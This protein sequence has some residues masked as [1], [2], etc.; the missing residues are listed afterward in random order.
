MLEYDYI[1]S[2]I[3]GDLMPH[4]ITENLFFS[5]HNNEFIIG[6]MPYGYRIYSS[7]YYKEYIDEIPSNENDL[8]NVLFENKVYKHP[9]G[10]I[11]Y[12]PTKKAYYFLI[13]IEIEKSKIMYQYKSFYN[14]EANLN[15]PSIHINKEVRRI[16]VLAAELKEYANSQL[17]SPAEFVI[18]NPIHYIVFLLQETL[19]D[20]LSWL[21]KMYNGLFG[22]KEIFNT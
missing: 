21:Y 10:Q 17:T 13:M 1:E 4:K 6:S 19:I 22:I 8:A 18:S 2:M 20:S 15:N 7:K 12:P 9:L 5:F 11:W 14:D 3:S 16:N